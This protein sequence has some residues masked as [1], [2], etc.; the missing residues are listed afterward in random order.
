MPS[1]K[2]RGKYF[3]KLCEPIY[4]TG[5]FISLSCHGWIAKKAPFASLLYYCLEE[6]PLSGKVSFVRIGPADPK[7]PGDNQ[8]VSLCLSC[9]IYSSLE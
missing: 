6:L 3:M 2:K 5:N 8:V 4:F 7:L 1:L 9:F